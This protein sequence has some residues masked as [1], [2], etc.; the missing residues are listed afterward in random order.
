MIDIILL[1]VKVNGKEFHHFKHRVPME[2]V[3]A[4][5]IAG[6]VLIETVNVI[7]VSTLLSD[8]GQRLLI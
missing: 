3:R 6:D 8:G 4:L 5:Y 1:Q 7:G 2:R